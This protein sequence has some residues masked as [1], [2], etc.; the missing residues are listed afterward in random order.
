MVAV[1]SVYGI[2]LVKKII[3]TKAFKPLKKRR[4]CTQISRLRMFMSVSGTFSLQGR[5]IKLSESG[6]EVNAVPRDQSNK[7]LEYIHVG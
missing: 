6:M 4:L 3:V 1:G 7:I 5:G 2:L